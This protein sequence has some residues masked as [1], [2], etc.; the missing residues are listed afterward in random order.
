MSFRKT[1]VAALLASTLIAAPVLAQA[2]PASHARTSAQVHHGERLTGGLLVPAIA[3]IAIIV[4][5]ILIA[6]HKN[7]KP[8][9]P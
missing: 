2:A 5:V 9:S 1:A 3:A 4:A 6:R 8:H 7:N